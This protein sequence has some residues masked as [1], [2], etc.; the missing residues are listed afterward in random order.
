MPDRIAATK[1]MAVRSGQ[2]NSAKRMRPP[3]RIKYPL[4]KVTWSDALSLKS[5][6]KSVKKVKKTYPSTIVTV[7]YLV[8][9]TKRAVWVVATLTDDKDCD[10]DVVIPR[11]WVTRIKKL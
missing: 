7:G 9:K 5:G 4:V 2:T 6:W 1:S 3:M 10:G 11:D 8:K